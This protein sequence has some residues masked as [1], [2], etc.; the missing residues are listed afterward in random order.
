MKRLG[1]AAVVKVPLNEVSSWLMKNLPVPLPPDC[2][3]LKVSSLPTA[4][5]TD[6]T[7]SGVIALDEASLLGHLELDLLVGLHGG[8]P[9]P[10][11]V[12]QAWASVGRL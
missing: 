4:R 5:P 8:G 7:T 9:D 2:V 1:S 11:E 10:D 12:L 3:Q 6:A